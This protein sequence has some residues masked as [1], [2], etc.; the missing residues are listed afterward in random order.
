MKRPDFLDFAAFWTVFS[1]FSLLWA[2]FGHALQV[3]RQADQRPLARDL[4]QTAQR[5]LAKTHDR[6]DDAEDRLDGLLA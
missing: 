4:L 2:Q 6:L 1:S 3:P 5:E